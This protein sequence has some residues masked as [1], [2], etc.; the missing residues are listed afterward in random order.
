MTFAQIKATSI[1]VQFMTNQM[2]VHSHEHENNKD[3]YAKVGAFRAIRFACTAKHSFRRSRCHCHTHEFS[4]SSLQVRE[5]MFVF[6]YPKTG[7]GRLFSGRVICRKLKTQAS[8]NISL[9]CQYKYDTECK[10]CMK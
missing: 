1:Q 7:V 8:R 4:S 10:Y 3:S 6:E 9:H 2:W 5:T